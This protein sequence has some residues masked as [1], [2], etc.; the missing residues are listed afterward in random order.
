MAGIDFNKARPRQ[1]AAVLLALS[2]KPGGFTSKDLADELAHKFDPEYSR[3]NASY[4][5]RK[6]RGKGMVKKIEGSNRYVVTEDGLKIITA[7]LCMLIKDVPAI[8]STIKSPWK[9]QKK[10]QLSKMD[11]YLF[12]IQ[13]ECERI[14][15]LQN[16]KLAA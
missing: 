1:V 3:R 14:R 6:F 15:D 16:I 11:E 7:I 8:L 4:D 12:S 5:L 9:E 13:K 2:M 10:E